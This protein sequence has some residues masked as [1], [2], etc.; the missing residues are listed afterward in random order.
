MRCERS[1]I[2]LTLLRLGYLIHSLGNRTMTLPTETPKLFR[3]H[4]FLRMLLDNSMA[5]TDRAVSAFS[6][7]RAAVAAG[8]SGLT[9]QVREKNR[10]Y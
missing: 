2:T 10:G 6:W 4:L 1:V 3:D 7:L 8:A 9:L 5:R